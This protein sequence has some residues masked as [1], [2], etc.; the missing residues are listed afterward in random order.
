MEAKQEFETLYDGTD[1]TLMTKTREVSVVKVR[2]L[3]VIEMPRLGLVFD[4]EAREIAL[5]CGQ[6][7]EWAAGLDDDSFEAAIEEGRRLNFPHFAK[8]QARRAQAREL[9]NTKQNSEMMKRLEPMMEKILREHLA[10]VLP[11]PASS[12]T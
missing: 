6:S 9:L 10:A 7:P 2:K 12:S 8:W 5:Y 4:D 3:P 11:S 1:L